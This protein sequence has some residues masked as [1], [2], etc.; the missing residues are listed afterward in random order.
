MHCS[1]ETLKYKFRLLC[2][3]P[4]SNCFFITI[5]RTKYQNLLS[6]A[7]SK[8]FCYF[9]D[10]LFYNVIVFFV[11]A[12]QA[13]NLCWFLSTS[14][15]IYAIMLLFSFFTCSFLEFPCQF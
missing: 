13:L 4:F 5:G 10:F 6:Q 7:I 9:F 3:F 12:V 15:I 1:V 11:H 8:L 14:G 2:F